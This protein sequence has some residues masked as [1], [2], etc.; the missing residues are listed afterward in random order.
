[1]ILRDQVWLAVRILLA[2]RKR[3]L[4]NAIAVISV[5]GVFVGVWALTVILSVINGFQ[6]EVREKI[7]G[8]APHIIVFHRFQGIEDAENVR[9]KV[10][11]V[12]GVEAATPFV[13]TRVLASNRDRS[14]G[15]VLWGIDPAGLATV[16]DLPSH[17]KSGEFL[18]DD[19]DGTPGIV[20]GHVLASTLRVFVGDEITL[21]S[22]FRG[23]RTPLGL[24]PRLSR[25]RVVGTFDAGMYEYDATYAFVRTAAAQQ[26]LRMGDKVVG[27]QARVDDMYA[28][29]EIAVAV[30]DHLGSLDY[31]TNDWISLNTN[32]FSAFKL[33]KLALGLILALI[34]V[35]AAFNIIGTLIMMVSERT[36]AIG[37]LMAMGS[38]RWL[39][40]RVFMLQGLII[41]VSGT[42]LG[43]VIG[44]LSCLGLDRWEF[45]T[46]PGDVYLVETLPVQMQ[47]ADFLLVGVGSVLISFLATVYPA[48][49]AAGL[50]PVEA[51]RHE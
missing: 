1:M 17:L 23:A 21:A 11:E 10:E 48:R 33:E 6:T 9:V 3:G 44:V 43:L 46:L 22:P 42:A 39:V 32:L 4:V 7:L 27:I 8:G 38:P 34:V 24:V 30:Q 47:T 20:L 36:R 40:S 26:M 5:G 19:G 14:E 13:Y 29:G 28:A 2:R 35:V 37:I 45:I 49:Q 41:G 25:F 15:V 16:S 18:P 12:A 50:E 51:I 31:F